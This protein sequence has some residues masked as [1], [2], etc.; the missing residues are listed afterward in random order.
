MHSDGHC[1][2]DHHLNLN[3]WE[4]TYSSLQTFNRIK[5]TTITTIIENSR[6]MAKWQIFQLTEG[7]STSI[8]NTN[9]LKLTWWDVNTR[10]FF[11]C[12]IHVDSDLSLCKSHLHPAV[13][14][15]SEHQQPIGVPCPER[16]T[17]W[18]SVTVTLTWE[19]QEGRGVEEDREW[20]GLSTRECQVTLQW[21]RER[22]IKVVVFNQGRVK[23]VLSQLYCW[24]WNFIFNC[25]CW[26][27][28]TKW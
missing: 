22:G 14:Q 13:R 18:Q 9:E 25:I 19:P 11:L 4:K 16:Q 8:L 23:L 20:V 17:D 3:L 2:T 28:I 1:A 7:S 15:R 12:N 6:K 10:V 24:R 26:V 27:K 5:L 21:E